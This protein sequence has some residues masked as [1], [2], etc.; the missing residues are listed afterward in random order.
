MVLEVVSNI[1]FINN[2]FYFYFLNQISSIK[3][4]ILCQKDLQKILK[5]LKDI[6]FAIPTISNELSIIKLKEL[7]LYYIERL[8]W[9]RVLN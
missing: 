7:N 4:Y 3:I 5:W 1:L 6:E 8:E 2:H 9:E